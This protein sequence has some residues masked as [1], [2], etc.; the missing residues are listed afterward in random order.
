M[1]TVTNQRRSQHTSITLDLKPLLFLCGFKEGS[2]S[3]DPRDDDEVASRS[4]G[5]E[6][7]SRPRPFGP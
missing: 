7:V 1:E 6:S 5:E 3:G 2:V 4:Y